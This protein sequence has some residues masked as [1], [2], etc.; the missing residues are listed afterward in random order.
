MK[1]VQETTVWDQSYQPNH[2]YLLE[3]NRMLAYIP[4]GSRTPHYFTQPLMFDSRRRT[5]KEL[6]PSPFGPEE[7]T[8]ILEVA[9]SNGAIYRVDPVNKT[10]DCM[11]FNF[12]G[13][14]RHLDQVLL[15][16]SKGMAK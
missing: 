8:W 14:C 5:F 15:Q 4:A 2:V 13:K 16:A 9:G 6:K 10:C 1:A 11:G 12:R 3:G 7:K